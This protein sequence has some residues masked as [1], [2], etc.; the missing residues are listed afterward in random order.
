MV[1]TVAPK[2]ESK[3]YDEVSQ[4]DEEAHKKARTAGS[5]HAKKKEEQG[6]E[7]EEEEVE[8]ATFSEL[9]M[10]ADSTDYLYMGLGTAGAI[11]NGFQ[12]PVMVVLLGEA[13]EGLAGGDV[14]DTVTDVAI[15]FIYLAIIGHFAAAA[16][17]SYWYMA[18][19]R[20]AQKLRTSWFRAV[21]KQDV[22]WFDTN[23]PGEMPS[24]ITASILAFER[25]ITRHFADGIQFTFTFVAGMALAF[26]YNAFIALVV[27]GLLPLLAASGAFLVNANKEAE[28]I[29]QEAYAKAGAV[30]YEVF[31]SLRT[32]L[33]FN[34]TEKMSQRYF[35][36]TERAE[37]AGMERSL[38]LGV[39]NGGMLASFVLMYMTITFFGS[40]L[41]YSEVEA[42][43]CDPSSGVDD[44]GDCEK[45]GVT[46]DG[47][48]IFIAMLCVA[49]GGQALGQIATAVQSIS[50]AR[51]ALRKGVDVM[52]RQPVIDSQSEEGLKPDHL[53]GR[54][55]VA[56]VNFSY[57]ARPDIQVCND[58]SITFEPGTVT[59]LVGESGSGKST[60]VNLVQRFYDPSAGGIKLDGHDLRELNV[61]WLRQR[62]ALVGQEPRLFTGSIA[63]N[64]AQGAHGQEVTQEQIE[65][66]ARHANAHDF[67]T[68]L[69]EGYRTQVGHGGSQLSGGQKQRVAIARAL[70]GNPTIL[71]LD[72][73]TSALDNKSEKVVQASLDQLM[74]ERART[75]IVI[76]HRLST[77]KNADNIAVVGNGHILEQG[78]HAEL[79][80]SS[81]GAYRALVEGQE[82]GGLDDSE[83]SSL[84]SAAA[85]ASGE[86]KEIEQEAGKAKLNPE[87]V[88]LITGDAEV[89]KKAGGKAKGKADADSKE[90]EEEDDGYQVPL[91]RIWNY[92]KPDLPFIL[93][94]VVGAAFAGAV[95]P[96]W[97]VLFAETIQIFYTPVDPCDESLTDEQCD[98]YLEEEADDIREDSIVVGCAWLVLL[99]ATMGGNVLMFYGFGVSS[100]K[101]SR[102]LRDEMFTA[103]VR[104]EVGY[105]DF[106]ENSVG[107]VTTRLSKDAT[108]IKAKTGEPIQQLVMVMFSIGAGVVISL[109]FMWPLALVTLGTLPIMAAATALQMSIVLGTG[110]SGA[111]E[112]SEAGAI[113]G[114]TIAAVTTVVS[115][116]LEM[117]L[118][119]RYNR[120]SLNALDKLQAT[121]FRQGM[122]F[123]ASFS[124]QFL[125]NALLFWF[126]AWLIENEG[127]TFEEF[128]IAMFATLFGVFGLGAASQNITDTQE[129]R[130]AL[131]SVFQLLDRETKIDPQSADGRKPAECHGSLALTHV[132]FRYPSRQDIQACSDYSL[133]IP[134]GASVGLVGPSGSGKSTAIQLLERFYDPDEGSVTADDQDYRELNYQW[135]HNQ[136]GYVGQEPVLFA[137]TVKENIAFG[138]GNRN[139]TDEEIVNAAK[140]ANAH[141]FIV[142]FPEGYDTEIGAAGDRLSGG[143]KQRVAIARALVNNPV[144]LLLDEATSALDSESEK[145]VQHALDKLIQ[146]TGLTTVMIA[147]RLSTVA[148]CDVICVVNSGKIVE[149]GTHE[150]LYRQKGQY[151]DLVNA[152]S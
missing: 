133:T 83:L 144:I 3:Q 140:R 50:S 104:Q 134:R 151:Y 150:E 9:F 88:A 21:M 40:W 122:A 82:Q 51:K 5:K 22:A 148:N 20:Q 44:G 31:A 54:I 103:L 74:S 110:S 121:A 75:T 48:S 41:L 142:K 112:S 4:R 147:H 66:A 23:D 27:I 7:E 81:L 135:L 36:Q 71:L 77:V 102:R 33:S 96:G 42:N 60:I 11:V 57:P 73:A 128:L 117:D 101:L 89:A 141:D 79:M 43:G 59:A 92:S 152:A 24:R 108:L 32:V 64:I 146:E 145:V 2:G 129:A 137:G 115:L 25:A 99:A 111:T 126:G 76:A 93:V 87:E 8:P 12:Q 143:Q 56:N 47:K 14:L 113:I 120:I 65:D 107:A 94:G 114:E 119:E 127:F 106:P 18:G 100:E 78:T 116:G 80:Q 109:I 19:K 10:L 34:G 138:A 125:N 53:H 97:G 58:Y 123:G 139:P 26:F 70:I 124:V 55:E 90:D 49:F 105:F 84:P 132:N 61:K 45:A 39:A 16:Q 85:I 130:R 72:E 68:R 136:I 98:D 46:V 67:I 35:A 28:E 37:K 38:K 149:Q 29:S 69:P 86:A 63:D 17:Y 62:M 95:F 13:F 15:Y 118:V 52:N 6:G 30:A 1:S 131:K 91:S